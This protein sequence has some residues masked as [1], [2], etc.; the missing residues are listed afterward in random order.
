MSGQMVVLLK[1]TIVAPVVFSKLRFS[2]SHAGAL[3]CQ[4]SFSRAVPLHAAF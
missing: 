1:P 4:A 3:S 2:Q